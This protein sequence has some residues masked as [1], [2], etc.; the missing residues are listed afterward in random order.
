MRSVEKDA[1]DDEEELSGDTESNNHFDEGE[2]ID[3]EVMEAFVGVPQTL[4]RDDALSSDG[5][6]GDDGI[7]DHVIV[8]NELH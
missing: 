1:W 4:P 8:R 6:F 3:S 7:R 2:N 5:Q